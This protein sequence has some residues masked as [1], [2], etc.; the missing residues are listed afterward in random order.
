MN[1]VARDHG[2]WTLLQLTC[3]FVCLPPAGDSKLVV[4]VEAVVEAEEAVE[5]AAVEVVV[6]VDGV[7]QGVGEV[8]LGVVVVVVSGAE[9]DFRLSSPR[10]TRAL[11]I[12]S[13]HSC[14]QRIKLCQSSL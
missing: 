8:A 5:A 3:P 4:E 7:P 1:V 13:C 12:S 6:F 11:L 14:I 10:I 9:G 2:L